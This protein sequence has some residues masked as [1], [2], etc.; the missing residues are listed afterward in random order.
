MV[1]IEYVGKKLSA[2]DNVAGSRAT[3]NGPGDVVEVTE[4][5]A[6]VLLRYPDQW[7]LYDT[8]D[9]KRVDKPVMVEVVGSGGDIE[10]VD[11]ANLSNPLEK[12][13]K[14]ELKAYAKKHFN[15]DLDGRMSSKLMVDQIEEWQAVGV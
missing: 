6:K 1:K 13:D 14:N 9:Q 10:S 5:Q 8:K 11:D 12:M 2:T 4:P 15:K 7:A 3:W